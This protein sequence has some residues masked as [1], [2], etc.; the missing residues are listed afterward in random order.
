M[1]KPTLYSDALNA[2]EQSLQIDP[3]SAD[4]W[5][6]KGAALAALGRI[7]E[8]RRCVEISRQKR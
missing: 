5:L 1:L 3:D 4:T 7:A 6:K 2:F 8:G